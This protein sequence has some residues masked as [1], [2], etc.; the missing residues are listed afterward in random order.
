MSVYD[1]PVCCDKYV[2]EVELATSRSMLCLS[3]STDAF[4]ESGI[5]VSVGVP[6]V[7]PVGAAGGLSPP[8]PL[9]DVNEF[10]DDSAQGPDAPHDITL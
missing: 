7:K 2:Q 8:P 5:E 1:V 10:T 3:A 9:A 6:F 4:Q